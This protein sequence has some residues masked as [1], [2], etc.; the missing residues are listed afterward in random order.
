MG[1]VTPCLC[2]LLHN[3]YPPFSCADKTR[4]MMLFAVMG[5]IVPMMVVLEEHVLV[6]TVRGECHRCYSKTRQAALESIPPREGP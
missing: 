2:L 6:S 5:V 3:P 1:A 4:S